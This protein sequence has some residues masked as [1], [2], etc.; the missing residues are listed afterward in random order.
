MGSFLVAHDVHQ[1][2]VLPGE[3]QA[4]EVVQVDVGAPVILQSLQQ[5]GNDRPLLFNPA[6]KKKLLSVVALHI[7]EAS[8]D[9]PRLKPNLYY[10]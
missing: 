2:Q 7:L 3:Q 5:S 1:L 9:P 6:T 4:V 10:H 8:S